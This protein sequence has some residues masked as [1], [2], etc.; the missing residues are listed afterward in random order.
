MPRLVQALARPGPWL[1]MAGVTLAIYVA[2][3]AFPFYLGS[4]F[5]IPQQD[6]VVMAGYRPELAFLYTGVIGVLFAMYILGYR[7]L[8][9]QHSIPKLAIYLPP[10]VFALALVVCYP[11]DGADLF[12]Y[13]S[14]GRIFGIHH[15]N[16]FLVSPQDVPQDILYSYSSWVSHTSIYGPVWVIISGF[17]ALLGQD[18]V[19]LS[20]ILFKL[21]PTAFLFGSVALVYCILD[22]I[23]PRHRDMGAFLLAWNPLVLFEV[24]GNGHN[25]VVMVFF[26][27][28]SILF[29]ATRPR[30]LTLPSLAVSALVKYTS[31]ILLPGILIHGWSL[32]PRTIWKS[33]LVGVVASIA[34]AYLFVRPFESALSPAALLGQGDTFRSSIANL[35]LMSLTGNFSQQNADTIAKVLVI[36]ALAVAYG[37]QLLWFARR[38]RSGGIEALLIFC[39]NS[40]FFLLLFIPRF[41]PWYVI[42]LLGIAALLPDSSVAR[43]ALLL[44]FTAFLSHIIFY[45]AWGIYAGTVNYFTIEATATPLVFAPPVLY[46]F[47][48]RRRENRNLLAEKERTIALQQEEIARL[49]ASL[50]GAGRPQKVR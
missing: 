47:Y 29:I 44:S 7:V 36:A 16:P 26:T 38:A 8:A 14:Q 3:F 5:A 30:S 43:R 17:L 39:A 42:W 32:K 34:V 40:L 31:V 48:C 24:A 33:I 18:N 10:V 13:I 45:F 4:R 41:L 12:V 20:L 27:L 19:W 37:Y 25:D 15:L 46:W 21:A 49:R 2:A 11:S 9:A 1:T 50:A 6:W 28:L 23:N 22:N 35:I